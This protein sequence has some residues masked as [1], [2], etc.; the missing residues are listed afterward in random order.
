PIAR[1]TRRHSPSAALNERIF[2]A[3]RTTLLAAKAASAFACIFVTA[4][5]Q[6]SSAFV[7]GPGP[8]LV[9]VGVGVGPEVVGLEAL[10]C[11]E[12]TG[13]GDP[14]QPATSSASATA[15]TTQPDKRRMRRTAIGMIHS[16]K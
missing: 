14:P 13:L 1:S 7:I 11:G 3:V 8:V 10:G 15:A 9:G 16:P 4:A 6:S 5:S 12:A 2:A